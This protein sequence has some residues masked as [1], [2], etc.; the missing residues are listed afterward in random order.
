MTRTLIKALLCVCLLAVSCLAGAQTKLPKIEFSD[1]TLENGLRV[2]I[3]AD[4][5]APVVST[6][7]TYNTGS[8]NEKPGR[9]GFA[10]LFEHMMF[11]GST[12]VGKGEHMLLIQNYGGTLNG[13]TNNDQTNYFEELPKNQLDMA[14]FLESDR[15]RGLNITPAN[16]DNQRNAVQEERRLGVDNQPYGKSFEELESMAYDN[17]PYHH[18]V[19]GSM[20]DLNAASLDDVKDFFRTYYAPNNAVLVVAGDV[21]SADALAK[22]KK[23]FGPIPRQPAPPAVS[24]SEPDHEKERRKTLDDSLARLPRYQAAYN[25]PPGNTPDSYALQILASALSTGRS[26]RMYQHLVRERQL[27]VNA[28]AFM[29]NRRGPGLFNIVATPRPGVKVEDLEKAI[30]DEIEAVKKDGITGQELDKVRVQLL[31]QQIQTRSSSLFLAN[32]IG[33]STV[34]YNDPNLVNTAYGKLSAITA[35]Q[36]RDVARKYLVPAHRSVVITMPAGRTAPAAPS[37]MR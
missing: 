33:T 29:Q 11:Q 21:G 25:A 16:L 14:L 3:V 12:N 31:R 36:V 18:S 2:I 10:H 24:I 37:G 1:T 28:F 20:E 23:Y 9:T 34:Y 13:S 26:S 6:S 17:F 27:A 22:V 19:I 8:R 30:D 15:M 35:E 5:F 4:H 7:L 32:Q